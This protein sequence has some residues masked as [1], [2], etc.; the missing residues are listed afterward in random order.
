MKNILKWT[1]T[2]IAV[3]LVCI[4]GAVTYVSYFLPDIPVDDTIVVT[5]SPERIKRGEYLANH[6]NLCMDCHSSRDFS[7]LTAPPM[8]GTKG[9]GGDRFDHAIGFP[10]TFYSRNITPYS[11]ES[12]SDG[13]IYRAITSGVSKDGSVIFPVMPWQAYSKMATEDVYSII[14]YLRSLKPIEKEN[15]PSKAD[16][17][18]SLIMNTFP[19]PADPQPKPDKSNKL[20]Y[21]KY[22]TNAAGCVECHTKMDAQGN[23]IAGM[24]FAGGQGFTIPGNGVVYSANLT[25]TTNGL[26]GYTEDSFVSKFKVYADSSFVAPEVAEGE[27]QTLMPW[28][29]Y[30]GMEEADL[31]AIYTYLNSLEPIEN[32]FEKFVAEI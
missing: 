4:I 32:E 18:V 31:R 27:F 20:A 25:P 24:E 12:W 6:V 14:A 19:A 8:A 15:T 7:I 21:G 29:M 22:L 28:M 26:K 2:V 5:S 3:L 16:F 11:L 1:A 23:K 13:E 30:A 10:G 9:A 17:P